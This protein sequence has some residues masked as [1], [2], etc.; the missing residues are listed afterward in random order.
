MST[1]SALD[2]RSK[3]TRSV[4]QLSEMAISTVARRIEIQLLVHGF[5]AR[6]RSSTVGM[7]A[8]MASEESPSS[9]HTPSNAAVVPV[10]N[11]TLRG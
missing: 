8:S 10:F 5:D 3:L 11:V 9:L 4:F 7:I 6:L 1:N 2:S